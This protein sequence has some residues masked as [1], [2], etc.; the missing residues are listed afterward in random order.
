MVPKREDSGYLPLKSKR[1]EMPLRFDFL[2]MSPEGNL[3]S[4]AGKYG[5]GQRSS[6]DRDI[7]GFEDFAPDHF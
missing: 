3:I 1:S 7:K 4:H 5:M 6:T 2:K